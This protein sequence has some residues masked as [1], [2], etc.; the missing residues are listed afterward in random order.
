MLVHIHICKLISSHFFSFKINSHFI[1]PIRS[2][3]DGIT[4][5]SYIDSYNNEL[6]EGC[7]D[8]DKQKITITD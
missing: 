1:S 7:V 2:L 4:I 6:E 5:P 8:L 3:P